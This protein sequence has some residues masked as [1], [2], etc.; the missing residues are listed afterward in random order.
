MLALFGGPRAWVLDA[1]A[2]AAPLASGWE[3]RVELWQLFP[4]LVHAALFG[5][6]Y[7]GRVERI[8]ARY[9]G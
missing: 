2:E 6:S 1:Y 5:G 8:A 4:L 9:A 3:D 7:R